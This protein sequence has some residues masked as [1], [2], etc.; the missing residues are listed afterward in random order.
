MRLSAKRLPSKFK[1]TANC[2]RIGLYMIRAIIFDCHGVL[3]GG[4]ADEEIFGLVAKLKTNYKIG[5]LSNTS[6]TGL[7]EMLSCQ[8]QLLFDALVVSDEIGFGKPDARAYLE[9]ARQLEEFPSDCLMID[10]VESNCTGAL[11]AGMMAIHYISLEQFKQEIVKYVI[12]T[13]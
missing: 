4:G 8:R 12:L 11:Q 2:A 9:A 7:D 6:T 5:L 3:A 13:S 10:D 1:N